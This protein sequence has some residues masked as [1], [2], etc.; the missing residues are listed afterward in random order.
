MGWSQ[1]ELAFHSKVSERAIAGFESKGGKPSLRIL[2]KLAD[3]LNV[4]AAWLMGGQHEP[5]M[6][7]KGGETETDLWQ[8]RAVRAESELH[9]LREGMRIL[10]SF[11]KTSLSEPTDK[12]DVGMIDVDD[13]TTYLPHR[14][15]KPVP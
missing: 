6:L 15:T 5:M 1:A 3:A 14:K 10:L 11:C 13:H 8:R 2:Q 4:G 9:R 12:D 7:I